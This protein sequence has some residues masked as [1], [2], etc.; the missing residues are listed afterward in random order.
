MGVILRSPGRSGGIPGDSTEGAQQRNIET[1]VDR[2][3][4]LLLRGQYDGQ[5][6]ERYAGPQLECVLE[7]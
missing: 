1:P 2:K 7:T 3:C 5:N 6:N 4:D